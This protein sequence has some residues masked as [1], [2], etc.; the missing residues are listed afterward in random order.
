MKAA[1]LSVLTLALRDSDR[2]ER[3]EERAFEAEVAARGV[4]PFFER[5][6]AARSPARADCDGR[7]AARDRYVRV[8]RGAVEER[9]RADRARRFGSAPYELVFGRRRPS[10]ADAYDFHF[11]FERRRARTPRGCL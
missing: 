8:C 5:V 11:E 9:L 3:D 4:V 1:L 10:G 7:K 2:A 6:C